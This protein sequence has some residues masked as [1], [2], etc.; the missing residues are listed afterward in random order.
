MELGG[1]G[2]LEPGADLATQSRTRG[3]PRY[4]RGA[5]GRLRSAWSIG[6]PGGGM[7]SWLGGPSSLSPRLSSALTPSQHPR[8]PNHACWLLSSRPGSQSVFLGTDPR[9]GSA[10]GPCC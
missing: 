9:E 7:G 10:A 6:A 1:C 4:G 2:R 8:L 3:P 5:A